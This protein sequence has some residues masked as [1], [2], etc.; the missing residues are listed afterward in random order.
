MDAVWEY[1]SDHPALCDMLLRMPSVEPR[2]AAFYVRPECME[3]FPAAFR[4][5]FGEEDF[6]LMKSE[7]FI[8]RGFLGEGEEH[9]KVRD[10]AGDYMALAIGNKCIGGKRGR[11]E[12]IGV[13]AG[14]TRKEMRV[15]LIAAKL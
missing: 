8:A 12:L 11:H 3:A 14:L 15:P 6:L 10:F 13:H 7:E 9:P 5:A 1:V 4:E 2:A